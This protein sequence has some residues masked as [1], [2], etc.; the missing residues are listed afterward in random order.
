[1]WAERGINLPPPEQERSCRA[2]VCGEVK[3]TSPAQMF[4]ISTGQT[5]HCW[6]RPPPGEGGF[7]EAE[8]KEITE[9]NTSLEQASALGVTMFHLSLTLASAQMRGG[10]AHSPREEMELGGQS[11][12][13]WRSEL[14]WPQPRRHPPRL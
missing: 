4:N 12:L 11:I 13:V 2:K 5:Q 9:F 8:R 1:M 10:R 7:E 3:T 14:P 6:L